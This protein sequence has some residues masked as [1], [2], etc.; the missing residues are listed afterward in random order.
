MRTIRW[1]PFLVVPAALALLGAAVPASGA[2]FGFKGGLSVATLR[3]SLPTYA[4]VANSS[5]IGLGGGVWVAIPLGPRISI[6]PEVNY[7]QKGRSFGTIEITDMGGAVIGTIDVTEAV[8]YVEVPALLRVSLPSGGLV[9]PYFVG[10]PVVGVTASQ[11][12]KVGGTF[13]ASTGTSSFKSAD[14]GA[15]LGAGI[16]LGRGPLRG[17]LETRYT[18]GLSPASEDYYSTDARNG[19]FLATIGLA[20]HR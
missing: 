16:E 18:L 12:L 15:A 7:V 13:S 1:S 11:K 10:G 9:S 2:V 14:F 8:D 20:I 17:T 4:L 5:R 6:Q 19:C 3:G